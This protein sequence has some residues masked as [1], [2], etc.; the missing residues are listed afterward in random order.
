MV[1]T[2]TN[3][4]L[5]RKYLLGALPAEERTRI[6]DEYFADADRFEEL[7]GVENDLIDSYVRGKLSDSERRQFERHYGKLPGRRARIGFA[8]ALSQAVHS[9]R[10]SIRA[11]K[12]SPWRSLPHFQFPWPHLQWALPS[13]ALLLVGALLGFQNYRLRRELHEAQANG[14][15]L[16]RQQDALREQIAELSAHPQQAPESEIDSQVARLEPPVDLTFRLVP[17]VLRDTVGQGDL[18]IPR[19]RPW[20]RLEMVLERDEYKT[21]KAV[22]LTPEAVLLPPEQRKEVLRG[23]ALHSHSIGGSTIVSWRFPS[24]SIQPGD[25]VVQLSGETAAGSGEDVASYSFR[26]VHK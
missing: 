3:E 7:V 12:P 1:P 6:E 20:V 25:Y 17:G 2:M 18:V 16:H 26:A 19:N 21:Y 4:S 23:T 11:N 24:N 10:E 5:M 13:A 15:Q 14:S 22:L 9:E 8:K